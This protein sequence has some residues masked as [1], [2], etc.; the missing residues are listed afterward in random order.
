MPV[1]YGFTDPLAAPSYA[2]HIY[3]V[4]ANQAAA[5]GPGF[6]ITVFDSGLDVNHPDFAGRANTTLLNPQS[7]AQTGEEYHGTM[8]ASTAAAALNGVG[9]Q[10]IYA[11]AAL[12]SYDFDYATAAS[13]Y[14]GF[15]AADRA[16]PSVINMSFGGTG[17]SRADYEAIIASFA[18]GS[19]LVAAAGN[20][21]ENGNPTNYPRRLSTRAHGGRDRPDRGAGLVL[22]IRAA[23][24]P[25][26]PGRRHP[27]AGSKRPT[28]LPPRR[29]HQLRGTDRLGRG[30]LGH[31]RPLDGEDATLR[32]D[33]A[34]RT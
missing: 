2:W 22:I 28:R 11:A 24:R 15:A 17:S 33:P 12:R 4:G 1:P 7:V 3:A 30:R 16:G 32:A 6:P 20:E 8:V 19:L 10:G 14:G 26:R 34:N 5:A 25:R 23:G 21:Y 9:A 18:G 27:R 13:Y 29:R 31:D